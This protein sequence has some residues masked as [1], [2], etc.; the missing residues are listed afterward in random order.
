VRNKLFALEM[1]VKNT[2]PCKFNFWP[3][4]VLKPVCRIRS[5]IIE[6]VHI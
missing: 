2:S 4:V 1:E 5:L 3:S 6:L